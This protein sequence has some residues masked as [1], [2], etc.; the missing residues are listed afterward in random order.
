MALREHGLYR[1]LSE[2]ADDAAKAGCYLTGDRGPCIDTGILV[3]YEG[4]LTISLGA[5]REMC[6][7]AGFSFNEEAADLEHRVAELERTNA[8]L[9]RERDDLLELTKAVGRA[10]KAAQ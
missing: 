10:V 1:L 5:L 2:P 9:Q 7:V 4:N 3:E 8:E 6:E